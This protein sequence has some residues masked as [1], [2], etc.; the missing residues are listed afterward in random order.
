MP[1]PVR[2]VPPGRADG[3]SVIGYDG[4]SAA[5]VALQWAAQR[6]RRSGTPLVV[7]SAVDDL[8]AVH[9]EDD[10]GGVDGAVDGGVDVALDG[11][12]T[13]QEALEVGAAVEEAWRTAEGVAAEGAALAGAAGADAT[14]VSV[15][16]DAAAALLGASASAESVVVARGGPTRLG[17]VAFSVVDAATSPVVLVRG[18]AHVP[19]PDHPV[20]V[21]LDGSA[22]SE[23]AAR[24]AAAEAAAS[25]A[26]LV[27]VAAWGCAPGGP[28]RTTAWHRTASP[29][30][31]D[32]VAG[33]DGEDGVA[34]GDG[35]E[36]AELEAM[37]R[38]R[39]ATAAVREVAPALVLE[40]RAAR[41]AAAEVLLDPA[42]GAGLLVLGA[43]GTDARDGRGGRLG[44]TA[45]ELLTSAPCPVAVVR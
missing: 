28:V 10:D 19:G 5:S 42:R 25:G 41:G 1:R 39:A 2:E 26:R 17:R 3:R 33:G 37:A 21:G 6:A 43:R 45:L 23:R 8:R 34:G 9:Q 20:V 24:F 14:P 44:L 29:G 40:R 36:P 16:G 7:L 32:G 11:T 18:A 22:S 35:V 12:S 38:L 30:G 15:L 31:E 13:A 27:L 4:S